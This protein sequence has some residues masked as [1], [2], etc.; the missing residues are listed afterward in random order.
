MTAYLI[1]ICIKLMLKPTTDLYFSRLN[2]PN[3]FISS[4]LALSTPLSS[5][6]MQLPGLAEGS[7][8]WKSSCSYL[9]YKLWYSASVKTPPRSFFFVLMQLTS[10]GEEETKEQRNAAGQQRKED[11]IPARRTYQESH[12][13]RTLHNPSHFGWYMPSH[14]PQ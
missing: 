10:R 5:I 7:S 11:G 9:R 13:A 12:S 3:L 2:T 1:S 4:A 8:S 14:A 6:L